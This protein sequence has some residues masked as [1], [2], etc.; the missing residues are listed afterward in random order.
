MEYIYKLLPKYFNNQCTPEEIQAIKIWE[1]D[2]NS[3]FQ[4]LKSIWEL[5]EEHQYINFN[6]ESSWE[7]L[8]PRL[9]KEKQNT[10]VLPLVKWGKFLAAA[11]VIIITVWGG[12]Q[13]FDNQSSDL[14]VTSEDGEGYSSTFRGINLVSNN[15]VEKTNLKNG[16]FVWLKQNSKVEDLGYIDNRYEVKLHQGEVFFEIKSNIKN[17]YK[18]FVVYT[19]NATISVTEA[20]FSVSTTS[21]QTI[22][23]I[24]E[25]NAKVITDKINQKSLSNGEKA[26]V[27]NG[28]IKKTKNPS[29]NDIAWKTGKF[30][31]VNTPL[32]DL[33]LI[34][35]PF[36]KVKIDLISDFKVSFSGNFDNDPIN[37]VISTIA[38]ATNLKFEEVDANNY[39]IIS[40]K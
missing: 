16:N 25:G 37:E 35:E 34:L 15:A 5:T 23:T 4:E 28:K 13:L 40:S 32:A 21:T 17:I 1:K 12:L 29:I 6:A 9:K 8:K 19:E 10:P 18:P 24:V 30:E 27:N 3:E 22:I 7:E 33:I 26:V 14:I 36:Y 2:F 11:V 39:Y 38:K 31:F 20:Q